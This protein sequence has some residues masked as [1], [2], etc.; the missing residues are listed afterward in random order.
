M[1]KVVYAMLISLD[2]FIEGPN[3]ELDWAF[4]DEEIH[5]HFNDQESMYDAH[6]YGRRLYE[7]MAAY[8]PTADE[9]PAAPDYEIEY[10]RIWKSMPKVVFS[11]S[12]E[13]VGWNARLVRGDFAEEVKR[14]KEQPGKDLSIGGADLAASAMRLGLVDEYQVYINPV[15]LG[16]GKPMFPALNGP[17]RL[18]PVETQKFGS[19]VVRLVYQPA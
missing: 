7:I 2:G 4:I 6:L 11:K 15:V 13:Q 8:W 1:R 9:N 12:L 5:Q 19:G 14:L 18:R 10:A 3:R 17:L 16:G